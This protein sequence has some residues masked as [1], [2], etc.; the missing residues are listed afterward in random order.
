MSSNLLKSYYVSPSQQNVRVIDSNELIEQKLERIRMIMPANESKPFESGYVEGLAADTIDM[1]TLNA[2]TDEP[3][4]EEEQEGQW[5]SNVIKA[6]TQSDREEYDGPSKEELIAEAQKEIE[7]MKAEAEAVIEEEKSNAYNEARDIGYQE[8]L[9]QA[10]EETE[11]LYNQLLSEKEQLKAQYEEQIEELEPMFIR[12]LTEIYEKI[13]EVDLS[14]S[15]TLIL[16][17]LRNSI[18]K[19]E[20]SKNFLV[21]V[22]RVDFENVNTHKTELLSQSNQ[23]GTTID[24]IE[25]ATLHEN[26]CMIETV[27]GIYDCGLG[28]QL[29]EL[30]KRLC[31]LS[32]EA[33]SEEK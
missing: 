6:E 1:D 13:F 4:E 5:G 18:R 17:L 31:L 20:G 15:K 29:S 22:S 11:E 2:L 10:K 32:F 24:V 28:T 26:E 21:H 16:T 8:G 14:A 23:E 7:A 25:D 30:K 33:G 12:T 9:Q 3:Q 19:I 27:N